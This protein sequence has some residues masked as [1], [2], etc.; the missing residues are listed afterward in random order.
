LIFDNAPLGIIHYNASG[1]ILSC[2]DKFV[3]IIGSS[4]DVLVG[5]N[6][7]R[8]SDKNIKNALQLSLA[9]NIGYYDDILPFNDSR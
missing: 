6:M 5:L 2:N 9:G 4:K 3:E 7:N 8:L 1:E